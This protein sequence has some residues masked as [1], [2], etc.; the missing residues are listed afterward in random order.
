MAE[1]ALHLDENGENVIWKKNTQFTFQNKKSSK[2][3]E[4][5]D[6]IFPAD[7]DLFLLSNSFFD[8]RVIYF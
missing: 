3:V 5:F 1:G 7:N 8:R 2:F 4:Q 6:I